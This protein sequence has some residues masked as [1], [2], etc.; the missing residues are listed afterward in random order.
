MATDTDETEE[1]GVEFHRICAAQV[2]AAF[3]G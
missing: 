1:E 2:C 3:A